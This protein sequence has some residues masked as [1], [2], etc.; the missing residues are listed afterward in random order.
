MLVNAKCVGWVYYGDSPFREYKTQLIIK[1]SYLKINYR[2]PVD[3]DLNQYN[4]KYFCQLIL[5]DDVPRSFRVKN[6]VPPE[7]CA[8]EGEFSKRK[9]QRFI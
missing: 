8:H 6:N 2:S 7:D 5:S 3:T 9:T 1:N 4:L